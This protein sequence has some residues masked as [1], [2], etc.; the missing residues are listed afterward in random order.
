[1]LPVLLTLKGIYSYRDT[2]EQVVDFEKLTQDHLFGIFGAVGSGKSTILEAITFALYGDIE[3]MNNRENRSYNMMNIRS[4][5]MLID[6]Q[7]KAGIEQQLY[8]FTV[9]SKRNAKNFQ[10]VPTPERQAYEWKNGEWEPL[11]SA[12]ASKVIGIS[13]E[14]FKR[15]VIIPQGKFQEFIQLGAA[16]RTKMMKELFN[17]DKFDYA[18]TTREKIGKVKAQ[19]TY[20][21]GELTGLGSVS[22][23]ELQQKEQQLVTLTAEKELI[24]ARKKQKELLLKELTELKQRFEEL[25]IRKRELAFL[26]TQQELIAEKETGLLHY[27]RTKERYLTVI[28]EK[29]RLQNEHSQLNEQ[30]KFSQ[31]KKDILQQEM[32]TLIAHETVLKQTLENKDQQLKKAAELIAIAQLK[33]LRSN[34]QVLQER[35]TKGETVITNKEKEITDLQLKKQDLLTNRTRLNERK[36][37]LD[38][39][40]NLTDWFGKQHQLQADLNN[41]NA[42]L[43][44]RQSERRFL[45]EAFTQKL[46]V[47]KMELPSDIDELKSLLRHEVSTLDAKKVALLNRQLEA[48]SFEKLAEFAHNLKDG[49]SCPLCGSTHHPNLYESHQN[50]E[51]LASIDTE[52]NA[53]DQQARSLNALIVEANSYQQSADHA[54]QQEKELLLMVDEKEKTLSFHRQSFSYNGFSPDKPEQINEIRASIKDWELQRDELDKV[55]IQ[56]DQQLNQAGEELRK[57]ENAVIKLKNDLAES[58]GSINTLVQGLTI[59]QENNFNDKTAENL[60]SESNLIIERLNKAQQE[61]DLLVKQLEVK[62]GEINQFAGAIDNIS[63]QIAHSTIALEGNQQILADLLKEDNL[64]ENEILNVLNQN[65]NS[66]VLRNEINEFKKNLAVAEERVK[67]IELLVDQKHYD[68]ALHIEQEAELSSLLENLS[69]TTALVAELKVTIENVKKSLSRISQLLK[70]KQQLEDRKSQLDILDRLFKANGFERFISV[71]YLRNLCYA[72]NERFMKFTRNQL[73]LELNEETESFIIRDNL[74][75]GQ[76]RSVK[77]LSGGQTFQAALSLALALADN[78]QQFNQGNQNFF[79]LDEG[80]GSLDKDSLHHVFETL[81]SLRKENRIVGLISHVD[82]MQQE[83]AT[84]LKVKNTEEAGSE[85]TA[86]WEE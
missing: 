27:E 50:I 22:E 81:K 3:R 83:I 18:Q 33:E 26:I 31:Q 1:M 11:E 44:Q 37:N 4:N 21:E 10:Q 77:T 2:D 34:E 55:Q 5:S 32:S 56:L 63:K 68:E 39:L 61:L 13:Y 30:L 41:S 54:L 82:D 71:V 52:L 35:I 67:N 64:I 36:P 40:A 53:I 14:N 49:D 45:A 62:S 15:T 72:A 69:H 85:I 46:A 38:M 70:E 43:V 25:A 66:E 80:F 74:N 6:F 84:Y 48:K 28:Q 8:R 79:F 19:L 65:I 47:V 12:D 24:E 59:L 60:K 76:T 29:K 42:Q 17:L 23:E 73:S 75:N 9:K 86:S 57:Y 78:I 16:E 51:T 58:K 20:L 7:F